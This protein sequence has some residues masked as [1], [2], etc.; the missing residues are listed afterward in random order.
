[1]LLMSTK[2]SGVAYLKLMEKGSLSSIFLKQRL[3]NSES[4][5]SLKH[6]KVDKL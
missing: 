5:L 2:M 1:M 4:M 3:F 6:R